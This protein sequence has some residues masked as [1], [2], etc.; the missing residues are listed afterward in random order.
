MASFS[1]PVSGLE[2]SEEA[3]SVISN[4]LANMNTVAYKTNTPEF[5][6]LLYQQ[7][8]STGAG[9]PIQVGLGTELSST[10]TD[11]TQGNIQDTGVP[12]D[13]AI[14]GNGFFQVESGGVTLYTRDGDF[15]TNSDNQLVTQD[16]S[17]VMGYAANANGVINNNGVL[18]PL[19]ID[20]GQ[21]IPAEPTQ[22]VQIN[23]NLDA[24]DNA[25]GDTP[26]STT[27]DAY[28]SL[29]QSHVLTFTFT[30]EGGGV[31]DYSISIPSAD[32]KGATGTSTVVQ[33]GQLTFNGSGQLTAV[34]NLPAADGPIGTGTVN[35]SNNVDGITIP[36]TGSG[37]TFADGAN[38]MTFNWNLFSGGSPVVSQ[39][40]SAS[41]VA[42]ATQDGYSSGS[43]S[44]YSIQ[45]SGIIEGSFTNGQTMAV[46]QIALANFPNT[47][48]LL[49]V[50]SNNYMATLAS[51]L[52][53]V[54]VPGT[55][56]L[57]TLTGD[58]LE[59]SNVDIASQFS[60]LI[61]QQTGYE[62][63]A[64]AFTTLDNVVQSVL[65]LIT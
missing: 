22:N 16:G 20:L 39:D 48:G 1:I 43:L 13:V 19:S 63:D 27:V 29:G 59:A 57:G 34:A 49:Q 15:T 6:D 24:S 64:K 58:S 53:S 31:W 65:N 14:S 50:G 61:T 38:T 56:S 33:N 23:M 2:A 41:A 12:T 4:N 32:L 60:Q 10:E 3:L 42:S 45:S 25:S 62:A 21:N 44:S 35:A 5:S 8:G 46:G 47:Q 17:N 18:S 11:F 26:Y 9:D 51:G 28:D 7:L 40:A 37:D 30:P 55:G 54:G 36:V 52:P